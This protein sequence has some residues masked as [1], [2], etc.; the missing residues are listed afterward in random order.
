MN[1]LLCH[2]VLVVGGGPA[3][4]ALA[5]HVAMAGRSV[6][7]LERNREARHKVCGE[8]LSPETLPF[9]AEMGIEPASLGAQRIHACRI[10]ARSILAEVELPEAGWAL[11]RQVLDEAL[12][13][14]AKKA[15]VNVLRGFTVE[16]LE[17][18]SAWEGNGE[19]LARITNADYVSMW[20]R[21]RDAFLATGKHDLR[22]W[23]RSPEGAQNGLVALKMYFALSPKEQT[24]LAGYVELITYP[25]GYAG[26]QLV[27]GGLA[28]LCVLVLR[29]RLQ[30]LGGSWESLLNYMQDHS[31]HLANRLSG[32]KQALARPLAL[33]SIPYGFQAGL[34]WKDPALWRLGDQAAVIPSFCGDGMAIALDTAR[35]AAA[36]YLDGATHAEFQQEMKRRFAWRIRLATQLS[37]AIVAA[38]WLVHAVRLWPPVLREIFTATRLPGAAMEG[39]NS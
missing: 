6:V 16:Q 14:R 33:S 9:L 10:A 11:T 13:V 2:D 4:A 19:W 26:L 39:A 17:Q 5:C 35:R 20:M 24:N 30:K 22:G 32:A 8:F 1:P 36:M 23:A 7:L 21:S 34:T 25:G 29:N 27:E 37:R 18:S 38:P 12:L 28:N 3:G 15:G 31:L